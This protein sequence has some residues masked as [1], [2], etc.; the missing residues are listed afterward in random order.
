MGFS[1][2]MHRQYILDVTVTGDMLHVEAVETP[3]TVDIV[4][5]A[6]D[7]DQI[8]DQIF[9]HK[10]SSQKTLAEIIYT[11]NTVH[12]NL[13]K[14]VRDWADGSNV[15]VIR[16]IDAN[17]YTCND[18]A[19]PSLH[20]GDTST[21]SLTKARLE[22]LDEE[23]VFSAIL[24]KRGIEAEKRTALFDV[25]R[26]LCTTVHEHDSRAGTSP[27]SIHTKKGGKGGYA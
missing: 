4:R 23:Y 22:A 18:A 20:E 19:I 14:T 8:Q 15:S 17:M 5:I 11:G 6:G 13:S 7:I 2:A 16:I 10:T 3:R 9:F 24:D 1:E 27:T 25:Y 12:P 21:L 26:Q